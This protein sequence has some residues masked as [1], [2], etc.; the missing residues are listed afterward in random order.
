MGTHVRV[1]EPGETPMNLPER[2]GAEIR[3]RRQIAGI[4][5]AELGP[6]IHMEREN[7]SRLERGLH[8]PRISTLYAVAHALGV[9]VGA[10]LPDV[11]PG[12]L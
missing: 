4:T 5:Q 3:R 6:C 7:V 1:A 11:D 8:M 12:D 10:L 2:I 9:S